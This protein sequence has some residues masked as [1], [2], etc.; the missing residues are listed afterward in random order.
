MMTFKEA[1]KEADRIREQRLKE[2]IRNELKRF[3]KCR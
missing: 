2:F 1:K 3:D